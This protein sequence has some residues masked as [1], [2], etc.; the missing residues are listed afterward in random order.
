VLLHLGVSTTD[1]TASCC[2]SEPS[3]FASSIVVKADGAI[4]GEGALVAK[5]CTLDVLFMMVAFAST[6]M[7]DKPSSFIESYI[8]PS[9]YNDVMQ[10]I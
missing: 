3:K 4:L 9:N 10:N 5:R 2:S 8:A 6:R 1:I 7:R